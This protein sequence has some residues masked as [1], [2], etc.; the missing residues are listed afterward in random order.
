MPKK[1]LWL[2][3][4]CPW[5][6]LMAIFVEPAA[7][8][9][10]DAEL[11]PRIGIRQIDGVAEFY[12]R[13]T[14]ERFIPRGSNYI[15]FAELRR[16]QLW[17]DYVFGAGTYRR[18][19]IRDEF[20]KLAEHGYNTVRMFFDHCFSGPSCIGNQHGDGLNPIFLDNMVDVM[21][22]AAEN[23]LYLVLTANVVPLDGNYWPRFDRQFQQNAEGYNSFY[24]NGYY[25]HAAGVAMHEQYWRDL[26]SGLVERQAPFEV[27]LGWQLQNEYWLFD[28]LLPL[29]L[30]RGQITI[31]NGQTYDLS[32]PEQKRQMVAD[33]VLFWIE[34][35]RAVVREYDPEGLVT[36]G[37]FPP[38]FPNDL[39]IAPGWYR[40]TASII[41]S[42]QVDFWSFHIYPEPT[43]LSDLM[44][45]MVENLGMQDYV[46]KPIVMGEVGAFRSVFFPHEVA[47]LYL[48]EWITESCRY[49]FDGWLIWEHNRRPAGDEVWSMVEEDDMMLKALAPVNWPDPC[50]DAPPQLEVSNLAFR[51]PVRVSAAHPDY[52]GENITDGSRHWV[53][54]AGTHGPQWIEIDLQEAQSLN[55]IWL[56]VAQEPDGETHHIV[57]GIRPNGSRILLANLRE[58]THDHQMLE[59]SLPFAVPDVQRIRVETPS[60]PSWV[61]WHEIE[62]YIDEGVS[63]EACLLRAPGNANLRSGPGTGNDAISALS[64]GTLAAPEGQTIG[65]DGF[66][67]YRIPGNLWVREDVVQAAEGCANLA[68]IDGIP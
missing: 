46:A 50:T 19:K 17:E 18:D 15:D 6:A 4:L 43:D 53:W 14:G 23:G 26:L 32:D 60:S 1:F 61:A 25:L 52:P 34:R 58:W 37:F 62:V 29:S 59:I 16:G 10:D 21:H 33:A 63:N 9:Q 35:L 12:N 48:Q 45:R 47:V 39:N 11:T 65:A 24:E 44:R 38:N 64:A 40:D 41:D 67:W 5:V 49:G 57:W 8:A 7:F 51:R 55:R 54:A 36:V 28:H 68:S 27:V 2:F 20:A 66:I 42:A 3:V 56:F 30:N 22:I 31:A 13:G